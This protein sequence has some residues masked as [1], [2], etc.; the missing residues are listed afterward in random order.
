MLD[1][2]RRDPRYQSEAKAIIE[3]TDS[4]EVLLKDLSITGCNIESEG[5]PHVKTGVRYKIEVL[6]ESDSH[7]DKFELKTKLVWVEDE[8]N[9]VKYGFSI[10]KSPKGKFFQNYVDYLAW[11]SEFE[12][13]PST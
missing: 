10:L 3:G 8:A 5:H 7:I 4:G 9:S 13:D 2:R 12:V 11:R 1:E 6:P